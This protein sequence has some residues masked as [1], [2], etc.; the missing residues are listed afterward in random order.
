VPFPLRLV[1][2]P[3][4]GFVLFL[5][6]PMSGTLG[7]PMR[8]AAV[9]DPS[10]PVV[11][12]LANADQD[13]QGQVAAADRLEGLHRDVGLMHDLTIAPWSVGFDP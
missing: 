13:K 7:V 6:L 10:D 4:R 3:P 2:T 1:G 11:H 8:P 12:L 5:A 9:V